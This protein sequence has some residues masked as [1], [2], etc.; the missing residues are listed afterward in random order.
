MTLQTVNK[1]I[2]NYIETLVHS[3]QGQVSLRTSMTIATS[4]Q[5]SQRIFLIGKHWNVKLVEQEKRKGEVAKVGESNCKVLTTRRKCTWKLKLK[6]S[7]RKS[8][9][10]GTFFCFLLWK[11]RDNRWNERREHGSAAYSKVLYFGCRDEMWWKIKF[12]LLIVKSKVMNKYKHPGLPERKS[13]LFFWRFK[14]P[15]E[16]RGVIIMWNSEVRRTYLVNSTVADKVPKKSF[17][18]MGPIL[19]VLIC[20]QGFTRKFIY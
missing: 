20:Q 16:I 5:E 7:K 8:C 3:M 14:H 4:K 2:V 17:E 11:S 10:L 12:D 13:I 18:S 1:C 19:R 15:K 9:S 6:V